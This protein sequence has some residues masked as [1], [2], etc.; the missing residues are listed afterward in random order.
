MD[1]KDISWW[2][3]VEEILT[4]LNTFKVL[5]DPESSNSNY[6]QATPK[7]GVYYLV[8][9]S[10]DDYF[11]QEITFILHEDDLHSFFQST[12]L[13]VNYLD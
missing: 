12:N 8:G 3:D 9:N 5:T 1:I 11:D 10:T 13:L 2:E 4:E 7:H 6:L